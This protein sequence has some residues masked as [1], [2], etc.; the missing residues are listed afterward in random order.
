[1]GFREKLEDKI[2]KKELEIKEYESKIIEAKAYLQGL[3]E[4]VKM[5]PREELRNV[6]VES[7][8]RPGSVIFKAFELLKQAGKPMHVADILKGLGK[9]TTKKDR[10]SISG[11]LGWY[12]RKNQIFSRPS[13]NTFG[14]IEWET[15]ASIEPPAD[16]GLPEEEKHE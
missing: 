9:L 15:D 5:L 12:V 16:F 10:V 13:P 2:K 4:A 3:Q 11:S 7:A 8:L 1:M 6:P 14:L